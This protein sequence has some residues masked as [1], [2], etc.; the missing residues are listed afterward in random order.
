ME[1]STGDRG[2]GHM[3]NVETLGGFQN[4]FYPNQTGDLESGEFTLGILNHCL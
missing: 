1:D 4:E 3:V 2:V